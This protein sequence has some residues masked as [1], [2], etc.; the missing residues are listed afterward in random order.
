MACKRSSVRLRYSPLRPPSAAFFMGFSV[1]IIYSEVLDRY[2]VGHTADIDKRLKEHNSGAS[3]FTS[4]AQDWLL[5]YRE[6]F[7]T[8]ALAQA[9]GVIKP[10][11]RL[12]HLT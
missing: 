7:E 9:S 3:S 5:K 4:K 6:D 1:Y 8:R 12:S 10:R 2:Y 11:A